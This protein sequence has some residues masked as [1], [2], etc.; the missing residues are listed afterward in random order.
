MTKANSVP[1]ASLAIYHLISNARSWINCLVVMFRTVKLHL[2]FVSVQFPGYQQDYSD[3]ASLQTEKSGSR[4]LYRSGEQVLAQCSEDVL[5][6]GNGSL[7]FC[8]MNITFT[9]MAI[10]VIIERG[11][12]QKGVIKGE[13]QK[14]YQ[15]ILSRH[16]VSHFL[17]F[18]PSGFKTN[19]TY[20]NPPFKT[21]SLPFLFLLMLIKC[22]KC[23]R[24]HLCVNVLTN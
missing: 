6:V 17:I 23:I 1:R 12:G 14:A 22:H 4:R 19:Y 10:K 20:R 7:S 18:F 24:C 15:N 2:R 3:P 13:E 11:N 5:N 21:S 8:T 9:K 16:N